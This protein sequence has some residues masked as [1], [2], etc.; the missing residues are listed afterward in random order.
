MSTVDLAEKS[1]MS[2]AYPV[3]VI[4]Q[5][6]SDCPSQKVF[7][8]PDQKL[9]DVTPLESAKKCL[10]TPQGWVLIVSSSNSSSGTYLL[11]PQDGSRIELPTL[12]DDELPEQCRCILSDRVAAPG[13]GV[14]V[15]DLQSPAMWFCRVGQQ[16]LPWSRHGYDIG[17]Y[18]LP[19]AYCSPT[20]K[21]NFFDVAAIKGTFFFFESN[22]SL[23]TLEFGSEQ[24]A[25]RLGAIAVPNIDYPDGITATYLVESCNDLFLVNIAFHGLCVDRPGELHVYRMDFSEP[26]SWRKTCCIR[27]QAFLLGVS[28][29]AASCSASG[30]GLKANCVYWLN[31]FSEKNSDLHVVSLE[32]G[33]SGVVKQFENVVGVQKPSWIVPVVA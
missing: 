17:W 16:G 5:P 20:K 27:D 33:T 1:N 22:G 13:C 6:G 2:M 4:P 10:A 24:E 29:F 23:G 18:D 14:L 9:E 3:L 8:L 7:S 21:K 31:C 11:N 28:N 32:D 30:C 26:P 19:E 12:G 15:F 25:P